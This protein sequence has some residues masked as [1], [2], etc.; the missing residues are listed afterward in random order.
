MS[1]TPDTYAI[2]KM[3]RHLRLCDVVDALDCIGRPDI[4]LVDNSIKP[5]FLGTK[6]WGPAVTMRA[7][8]SNYPMRA[9]PRDQAQLA[10]K[11]WF[12]EVPSKSRE[13]NQ[14]VKPG[15]VVVMDAHGCREVGLW[16]SNNTLG[17]LASGAIGVVTDGYA[18]DTAELEIIKAP[19]ACRGRGRTYRPGRAFISDVQTPIAC[20]HTLVRPG[21][22]V[23]CD[24]DGVV[25]VPFEVAEEVGK[26]ASDTLIDDEKGRRRQYEKLGQPPDDTVNVEM[27]EEFYKPWR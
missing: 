17:V 5:L 19:V 2:A 18:R 9:L 26:I 27:L 4:T 25:V 15:C 16:G 10:Q 13:L 8:P 12:E 11:L 14:H 23:G 24:D 7:L 22:I 20:G 1:D 21:D 3:Y 6:F